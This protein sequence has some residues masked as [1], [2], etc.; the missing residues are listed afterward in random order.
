MWKHS[1]ILPLLAALACLIAAPAGAGTCQSRN[2]LAQ[3]SCVGAC[4]FDDSNCR[5]ANANDP[6]IP[7]M[8]KSV[9][10]AKEIGCFVRCERSDNDVRC[11]DPP[12]PAPAR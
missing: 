10:G 3:C 12:P 8:C 11:N 5:C 2:T 7:F 6:G 4:Q 9:N 1:P